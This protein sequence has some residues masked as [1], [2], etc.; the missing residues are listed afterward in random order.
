MLIGE[1]ARN[2]LFDPPVRGISKLELRLRPPLDDVTIA[3]VGSHY[4]EAGS[5]PQPG[6]KCSPTGPIPARFRSDAWPSTPPKSVPRAPRSSPSVVFSRGR[7]S[8]PT[9]PTL[10]QGLEKSTMTFV[11]AM[12]ER[13]EGWAVRSLV[14]DGCVGGCDAV[15][16]LPGS[17]RVI[18]GFACG[19]TAT[20]SCARSGGPGRVDWQ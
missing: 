1:T 18:A 16:A 2:P 3:S 4:G 6:P 5:A 14:H 17:R 12:S 20:M 7:L 8:P 11:T 19:S 13:T 10:L 15:D 9:E